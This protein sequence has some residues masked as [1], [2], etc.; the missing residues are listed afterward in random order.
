MSDDGWYYD[1]RTGQVSQGKDPNALNRMGPYPDRETARR[2]LEIASE[3]NKAADEAEDD[4][5]NN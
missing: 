4:W 5:K 3:R 1:V 2:A